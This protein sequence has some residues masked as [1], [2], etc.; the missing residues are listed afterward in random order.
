MTDSRNAIIMKMRELLTFGKTN[1]ILPKSAIERKKMAWAYAF[2]GSAV[3]FFL[4]VNILP[5]LWNFGLSLGRYNLL[6]QE[7]VF[8]GLGNYRELIRD[9]VFIQ[10]LINT[11]ILAGIVLPVSLV[12]SLGL[13]LLLNEVRRGAGLFRTIYFAPVITSIVAVG[14][15]WSW[16]YEPNFGLFNQLLIWLGLPTSDFLK[17]PDVA[18]F[19]IAAVRI[20]KELGF[21]IVIFLAGL[22]AIP[23]QFNEAAKV[24]GAGPW[25]RFLYV[26]L[27]L[28]NPTLV[29][30]A[31]I[32]LIR[33]LQTFAL[34]YIMTEAGGPLNRTRTLVYEIEET[35][36]RMYRM[37]YGAAET[38]VLFLFILGVTLLQIKVLS[39]RIEY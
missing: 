23:N 13:A 39:R 36:F 14:Y 21:Q 28:L 37:G 5:M 30:L 15:I 26:T 33:V 29:F 38:I 2:V 3:L 34:I 17:N 31:V 11:L 25:Q 4:L 32:G 9:P 35:A 12:L 1:M 8:V 7:R 20:W 22:Q 16:L 18:I 27:P 10:S 24:D 19:A 6:S